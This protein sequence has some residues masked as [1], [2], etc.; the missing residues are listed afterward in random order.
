VWS[1]GAQPQPP[2]GVADQHDNFSRFGPLHPLHRLQCYGVIHPVSAT[3]ATVAW[4]VADKSTPKYNDHSRLK[5]ESLRDT[6]A[7]S[8]CF[9][10]TRI[11][12]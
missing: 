1:P 7:F 12:G 8:C 6:S 11:T 2:C 4:V 5:P 10:L 9:A 3:A